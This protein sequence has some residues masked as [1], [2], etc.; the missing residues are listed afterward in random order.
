MDSRQDKIEE[1]KNISNIFYFK[2][3]TI[4]KNSVLSIFSFLKD[5]SFQNQDYNSSIFHFL[6]YYCYKPK[7]PFLYKTDNS[8]FFSCF[9]SKK[10][11][12]LIV[13]IPFF[14]SRKKAILELIEFLKKI[15][16]NNI[17]IRDIDDDFLNIL[18]YELGKKFKIKSLKEIYY[19]N[20]DI[21]KTL[22]LIG[23]NFSNLRWHLNSF[24]KAEHKIEFLDL[25]DNIKEVIHLI[26]KWRSKTIKERGFSFIDVRSYKMAANYFGKHDFED[27]FSSVLKIDGV[28]SAFNL[29]Y[30]IGP[31]IFAHSVGICDIS[32]PH[33]A[34]FSQYEFW[35]KIRNHGFKYVNDGPTWRK[36]LGE[37]KNKFKPISKKRYYWLNIL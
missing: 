20:Y 18:N 7:I 16:T 22:K 32:I 15:D 29:G 14:I 33:L 28:V 1:L 17:L 26:G 36:S 27:V 9:S 5:Y 34:E 30:K 4:D 13:S 37:F 23:N 3:N 24:N 2:D 11:N 31:D 10:F 35:Q 21:D 25:K 6:Q 8:V 19:A 12:E